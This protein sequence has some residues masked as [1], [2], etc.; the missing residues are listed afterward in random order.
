[1][2]KVTALFNKLLFIRSI[3]YQETN[4]ADHATPRGRQVG[5]SLPSFKVRD[6]FGKK[7]ISER[8]PSTIT[9]LIF[10][11][12]SCILCFEILHMLAYKSNIQN[13]LIFKSDENKYFN[14]SHKD[15]HY[16]FPIIRSTKIF[17]LFGIKKVPVILT[18]SPTGIIEQIDEISDM[19]NILDHLTS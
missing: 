13:H 14:E 6:Q 16:K 15:Y 19:E 17:D 12:D 5:E 11:S 8:I 3:K 18:I 10:L 1:M 7:I 2:N 4:M 9:K